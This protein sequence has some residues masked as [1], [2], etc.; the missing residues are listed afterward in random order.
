LRAN[1]FDRI[2]AD[3]GDPGELLAVEQ[4]QCAS[5]TTQRTDQQDGHQRNSLKSLKIVAIAPGAGQRTGEKCHGAGCIG[6]D[7][8]DA[9]K[10]QRR[11]R[12]KR[13]AAS[14]GIHQT[15]HQGCGNQKQVRFHGC[16]LISVRS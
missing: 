14:H 9:G 15:C 4:Q 7:G 13:S 6:D 16:R 5:N 2:Q 11:K 1:S 12:K 8:W 3:H 10:N